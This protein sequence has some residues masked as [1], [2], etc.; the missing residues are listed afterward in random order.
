MRSRRI[1]YS[2]IAAFFFAAF[3]WVLLFPNF[4]TASDTGSNYYRVFLNGHE[5]GALA[6]E[7]RIQDCLREARHALSDG[8]EGIVLAES[9]LTLEA[10]NVAIGRIDPEETIIEGMT[11]ALREGQKS[12]LSHSFTVKINEY[13]VNLASMSDVYELIYA[14]KRQIDNDDEYD[15]SLNIDGDREINVLTASIVTKES[16]RQAR[17][18]GDGLLLAGADRYMAEA[19]KE[20]EPLPEELDFSAFNLGLTDLQLGDKVEIVESYLPAEE[21]T[22]VGEAISEV[23]KDQETNKVYEVVAGDAPILIADRFGLTLDELVAMNSDI[24]TTPTSPIRVGDQLTVTVPEP[25]LSVNYTMEEYVEEDFTLPTEYVFND[26]WYQDESAVIREGVTG[27]R[28]IIALTGYSDGSAVSREIVKEEITQE[29]VA[30][31]VERGT[32]VRPIYI[33]PISGGMISSRFGYRVLRG[34]AGTHTGIDWACPTG[35]SIFASCGGRVTYAGW[36]GSY[37]YVVFID[38]PDGRQTRYAHMSRVLC[39][40]GQYVSQLE[41]IGLS[42]S[43]GNSTGP[44]VHFEVRIGGNPVDP[45]TVIQ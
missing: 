20:A 3:A 5:I 39:S 33:K 27:H 25:L 44:H 32:K 7:D 28:R 23:T 35:T 34:K 29:A 36:M 30:Q 45:L 4:R 21:I 16:V 18:M 8:K 24:L 42:G 15:V 14:S 38:H 2:Y 12:T 37:G 11:E 10:D 22:P 6:S 26:D 40:V 31:I 13:A 17:E 41:R 9:E 1:C 43:T 19:L